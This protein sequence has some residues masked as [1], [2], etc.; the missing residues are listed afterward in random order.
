[1]TPSQSCKAAGLDSLKELSEISGVPVSTLSDW[2]RNKER[3]FF[4][5]LLAVVSERSAK[6]IPDLT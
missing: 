1:M 5:I 6:M 2:S 4:L 3:L